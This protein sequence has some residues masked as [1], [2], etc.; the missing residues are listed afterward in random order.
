MKRFMF[1]ILVLLVLLFAGNVSVHAQ[2]E[3]IGGCPDSF[4]LHPAMP[5]D[6]H[7]GHLHVGTDTDANADGWLCMKH[8][9]VNG[10]IHVHIDNN[11]PL[12]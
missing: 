8:V 10:H 6:D 4:E 9:S 1:G 5:H 7:H 11:I 2:N 3:P 12:P